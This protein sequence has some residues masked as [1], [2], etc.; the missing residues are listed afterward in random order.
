[1]AFSYLCMVDVSQVVKSPAFS[2]P[3]SVLLAD[4]QVPPAADDGLIELAHHLEGVAQVTGSLGFPKSVAHGT[5]QGQV[6][7]VILKYKNIKLAA[8]VHKIVC[9]RAGGP[10]GPGGLEEVLPPQM[11][12]KRK[13]C[14][15]NKCT[16]KVCDTCS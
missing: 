9:F 13:N 8:S 2:D 7:F 10:L 15:F 12:E 4:F 6:V 1:M 14:V 16:I 11:W 3:V 5:S